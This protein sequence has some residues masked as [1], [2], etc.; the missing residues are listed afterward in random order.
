VNTFVG[1]GGEEAGW[2]LVTCATQQNVWLRVCVLSS[3]WPPHP[4]AHPRTQADLQD[5]QSELQSARS[6]L[7]DVQ[8]ALQS[9]RS[10][11]EAGGGG[12]GR[13]RRLR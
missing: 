12:G 4:H 3:C 1:S 2:K 13:R 7:Q 8:S 6:E 5:V 11:L 9:A 10:E